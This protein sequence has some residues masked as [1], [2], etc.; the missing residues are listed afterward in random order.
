MISKGVRPAFEGVSFIA[1]TVAFYSLVLSLLSSIVFFIVRY[2]LN[3]IGGGTA[4]I[5]KKLAKDLDKINEKQGKKSNISKFINYVRRFSFV[6]L[7]TNVLVLL[8][9]VWIIFSKILG[10]RLSADNQAVI[11]VIAF[12]AILGLFTLWR[13]SISWYLGAAVTICFY[14]LCLILLLDIKTLEAQLKILN[15]GG[16]IPIEITYQD[17]GGI[18]NMN[19]LMRSS[20]SLISEKSNDGSFVE[21]PLNAVQKIYYRPVPL[22]QR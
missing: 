2:I 16:G 20:T 13:E 11:I 14:V 8:F 9:I 22:S 1:A 7:L 12:F 18:E 17:H 19:L 3:T 10:I 15:Y 21:V 6:D 4:N 5:I